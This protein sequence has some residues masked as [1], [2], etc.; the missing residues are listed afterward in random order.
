MDLLT[1]WMWTIDFTIYLVCHIVYDED[2]SKCS[3]E[4]SHSMVVICAL[5]EISAIS[6]LMTKYSDQYLTCNEYIKKWTSFLVPYMIGR[7]L[8][9][10]GKVF[11]CQPRLLILVDYILFMLPGICLL[12]IGLVALLGGMVLCCVHIFRKN[13]H[14]KAIQALHKMY[15]NIHLDNFNL[16]EFLEKYRQSLDTFGMT[17]KD[18]TFLRT[19][20]THQFTE[21]QSQVS[22][23]EKKICSVCLGHFELQDVVLPHPGCKHMFHWDCLSPWLTRP[24]QPC[25]CPMCK[26]PTMSNMLIDFNEKKK[27]QKSVQLT[28]VHEETAALDPNANSEAHQIQ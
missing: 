7:S 17:E 12:I 27:K 2:I 14:K 16:D 24:N 26:K 21:D 1:S 25:S 11:R 15:E 22:E 23:D 13:A 4:Y 18:L 19:H 10:I 20:F 9:F 3:S 5:V 8:W 28:T 6:N